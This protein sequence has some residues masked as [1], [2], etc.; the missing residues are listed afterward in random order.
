MAR[1]TSLS[2]FVLLPENRRAWLAVRQLA[3]ALQGTSPYPPQPLFLFGPVGSGK[4]HLVQGLVQELTSG[5]SVTVAL[6]DARD[7]APRREDENTDAASRSE[8]EAVDLLIIEDMQFLPTSAVELLVQ[9]LDARQAEC[10]PTVL[11]A[12][13]GPQRLAHGGE[14]FP[15]RLTSRLAAGLVVGL[16]PL[17]ASSRLLFLRELARRRQL[18]V[19]A[20]VLSWLAENLTGGGRQLEGALYQLAT[21]ARGRRTPWTVEEVAAYFQPQLRR[22]TVEGIVQRVGG[23]FCVEPRLLQSPRRHRNILVPRQVG[24][25]LARKLTGLTLGQIGAYFGGRDHTTVLHAC[26][27]IERAMETDPALRGTVRQIHAELA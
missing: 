7:L 6:V 19:A 14:R 27:R 20:E 25:Y 15:V 24:M 23:R 1:E 8:F 11:T 13:G 9:I 10:R 18:A 26:R 21:L 5:S 16:E 17:Q 3:D 22:T 4:T 2:Q 12:R